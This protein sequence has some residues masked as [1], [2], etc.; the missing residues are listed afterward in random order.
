MAAMPASV[1]ALVA[2]A[3]N[4]RKYATFDSQRAFVTTM[5]RIVSGGA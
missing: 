3:S 1:S 5:F 2:I 4:A